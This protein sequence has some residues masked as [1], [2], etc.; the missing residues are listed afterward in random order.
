ME[1]S[2]WTKSD[3][4][5]SLCNRVAYYIGILGIIH[6]SC[7]CYCYYRFC[8]RLPTTIFPI[9]LNQWYKNEFYILYIILI[10][11][12]HCLYYISTKYV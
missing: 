6:D 7:Y 8:A 9:Y 1:T 11:H 2:P 3:D 12:V 10:M 4:D 5:R